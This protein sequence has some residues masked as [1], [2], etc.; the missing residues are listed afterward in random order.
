MK[1]IKLFLS[2]FFLSV[3]FLVYF[4]LSCAIP[5]LDKD[6]LTQVPDSWNGRYA[7]ETNLS[8]AVL[9]IKEGKIFSVN[10]WTLTEVFPENCGLED[11]K[12]YYFNEICQ[13]ISGDNILGYKRNADSSIEYFNNS[14]KIKY[15]RI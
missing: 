3:I 7:R 12:V 2:A 13:I 6:P 15:V 4:T 10:A 9:E 11:G 1:S 8:E 5:G 14:N